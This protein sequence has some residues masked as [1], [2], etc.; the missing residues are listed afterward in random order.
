MDRGYRSSFTRTGGDPLQSDMSM[1]NHELRI[2][3]WSQRAAGLLPSLERT[4]DS[5]CFSSMPSLHPKQPLEPGCGSNGQY[6]L[7]VLITCMGLLMIHKVLGLP[8]LRGPTSYGCLISSVC[9]HLV[10]LLLE[11]VL[12]GIRKLGNPL[13]CTHPPFLFLSLDSLGESKGIWH[14]FHTSQGE[15]REE[16]GRG[17]KRR[18]KNEACK[19]EGDGLEGDGIQESGLSDVWLPGGEKLRRG[20]KPQ[21]DLSHPQE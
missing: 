21:G 3:R 9:R 14:Q 4:Q 1:K 15:E 7:R 5:W 18:T 6:A 16:E 2:H 20:T 19:T 17:G 8:L 12:V 11:Q 10:S 13:P